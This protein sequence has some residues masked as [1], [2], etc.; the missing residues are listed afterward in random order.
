MSKMFKY[1]LA[2][3]SIIIILYDILHLS[4]AQ[5]KTMTM[6]AK[7]LLLP[8]QLDWSPPFPSCNGSFC[9]ATILWF[10]I[11]PSNLLAAWQPL[12][13]P[14]LLLNYKTIGPK[15][16]THKRLSPWAC[17]TNSV[18][19]PWV[20]LMIAEMDGVPKPRTN[21]APVPIQLLSTRQNMVPHFSATWMPVLFGS[22]LPQQ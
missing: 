7:N 8:I 4:T 19:H 5:L 15:D 1:L 10:L 13:C 18:I 22:N 9:T 12:F 2:A 17:K 20:R 3:F 16:Q 11:P 6:T 14:H 21:M